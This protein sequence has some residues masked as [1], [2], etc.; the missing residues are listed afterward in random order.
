MPGGISQSLPLAFRQAD[1]W[2]RSKLTL[3]AIRTSALGYKCG[4]QKLCWKG[5]VCVCVRER[6]VCVCQR[7]R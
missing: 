1:A 2:S 7:E 6:G 5:C 4:S 3:Q